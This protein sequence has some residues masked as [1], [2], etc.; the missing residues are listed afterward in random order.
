MEKEN[1][2]ENIPNKNEVVKVL[3][4]KICIKNDEKVEWNISFKIYGLEVLS[5]LFKK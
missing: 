3:Y 1:I 2:Y 5:K 4:D